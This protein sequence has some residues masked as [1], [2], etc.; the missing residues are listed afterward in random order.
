[1]AISGAFMFHIHILLPLKFVEVQKGFEIGL[2]APVLLTENVNFIGTCSFKTE[3]SSL[4]NDK[5]LD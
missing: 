5:F 2:S 4:P 3:F 1:M